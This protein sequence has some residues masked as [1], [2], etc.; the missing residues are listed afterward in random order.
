ML[1]NSAKKKESPMSEQNDLSVLTNDDRELLE[2]IEAIVTHQRDDEYL[3]TSLCSLGARL[4]NTLPPA[5]AAFR[6]RLRSRLVATL[7]QQIQEEKKMSDKKQWAMVARRSPMRPGWRVVVA[8]IVMIALLF[9]GAILVYPPVRAWAQGILAH[10]G[11][12]LLTNAP[13]L[14]EQMLTRTPEPNPTEQ[15]DSTPPAGG[16]QLQQV[17]TVE[18]ARALA[19]FDVLSPRYVPKD[20]QLQSWTLFPGGNNDV[21]EV[22]AQYIPEGTSH[23]LII[24]QFLYKP[25]GSGS[26]FEFPV[27]D[28]PTVKVTVR[29]QPG[30]WVEGSKQGQHQTEEGKV[31]LFWFYSDALP[32]EEMLKI[33]ESLAP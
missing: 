10:I 25:Q 32:L 17:Q 14:P 28:A 9:A 27:G 21:I 19:R 23:L 3:G 20:Y 4:A 5:N 7:E 11:P 30:V 29:G 26:A 31:E 22:D 33:A 2:Q 8:G 6:E 1:T 12:F 18:E 24:R 15:P 13:T 16:V